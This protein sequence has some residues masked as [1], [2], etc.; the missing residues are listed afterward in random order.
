MTILNDYPWQVLIIDDEQRDWV[1]PMTELL[2]DAAENA[3]L[4]GL[5]ITS[6]IDQ[7]TAERLLARRYFHLISLDMRLP[8][9]FGEAISVDTGEKLARQ[10]PYV[11]FPKYLIYSQTLRDFDIKQRPADA[12]RVL[13]I[14]TDQYAK[15]TGGERVREN[16]PVEVLTVKEWARRVVDSFSRD[17][18][19]L[20]LNP[21]PPRG[22]KTPLT[23]IGAYLE[24]GP[25]LLPPVLARHLQGL[26]SYWETRDATRR[27]D[28]ADR[29]IEV[30][31]RLALAQTAVLMERDSKQPKPPGDEKRVTCV[32]RLKDWRSEITGW[33]FSN[34][35]TE[36]AI[37]ALDEARKVR[38]EEDHTHTI[39]DPKRAWTALR[40]PL[41]YAL[42]IAA[43]WVRHPLCIDLRYS[44]DGW[45]AECLAGVAYPRPRQPL[46]A[47]VDFPTE[48]LQGSVW[49]S[50]WTNDE[51]PQQKAVCWKDSLV[52]DGDSERPWWLAVARD[53][54]GRQVWLDLDSGKKRTT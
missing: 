53:Q 17:Q 14:P 10:F 5:K 33:N 38:N 28:T 36:D 39:T 24:F 15:P 40:V 32:A 13:R 48:A 19:E 9:R 1:V 47:N 54:R 29:F 4:S 31:T 52:D 44:R 16:A 51:R 6:A 37:E 18:P 7:Q 20:I 26:A 30:T 34:Y 2:Q 42:D 49:Q 8:E 21:A 22:T 27:V 45:N 23:V 35:L 3:K 50:V 11:G 12:V 41:Q 25:R 43:Y 46:P